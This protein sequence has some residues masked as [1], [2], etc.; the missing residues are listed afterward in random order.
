M[1]RAHRLIVKLGR[2]LT[3]T[4]EDGS[5]TCYFTETVLGVLLIVV[6]ILGALA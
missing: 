4:H 2:L 3:V 1:N 6:V 5:K